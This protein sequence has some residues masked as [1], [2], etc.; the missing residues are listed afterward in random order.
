M[1]RKI[2][3][4]KYDSFGI[5]NGGCYEVQKLAIVNWELGK[6]LKKYNAINNDYENQ[7]K[8]TYVSCKT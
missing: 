3:F 6:A 2:H 8:I 1:A 5:K 7:R 4:F